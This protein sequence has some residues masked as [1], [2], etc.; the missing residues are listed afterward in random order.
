MERALQKG[1]K[2][3]GKRGNCYEQFLHFPQCFQKT[4]TADM[5][6]SGLVWERVKHPRKEGFSTHCGKYHNLEF[7]QFPLT[8][9]YIVEKGESNCFF[10]FTTMFSI[11]LTLYRT[12]PT[13]IPM[14]KEAFEGQ[15]SGSQHFLLF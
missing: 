4:C 14:E 12:I 10:L 11:P 6:K 9:V 1:G 5:Y 15:N 7:Y 3:C 13:L 2:D 8:F